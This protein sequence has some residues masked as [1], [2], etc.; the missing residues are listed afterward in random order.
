MKTVGRWVLMVAVVSFIPK[1]FAQGCP[2]TTFCVTSVTISPGEIGG[3][4]VQTAI[5]QVTVSLP[6]G[7]NAYDI[8]IGPGGGAVFNACLPPAVLAGSYACYVTGPTSSILLSGTNSTPSILTAQVRVRADPYADPGVTSSFLIDPVGQAANPPNQPDTT[9]PDCARGGAPINFTTGNTWIEQTDYNI[10]GLTGGLHLT[11]TWNSLWPLMLPVQQVGLFGDS[12]TSNFE[13]RIQALS[14]G[15]VQYWKAGGSRLFYQYNNGA[16][17]Y[18]LTAPLDDQ[19]TISVNSG[20]GVT[21]ILQK[22]G[23]KK[24]FN[25]AGYLTSIIDRNGNTTTITLD[26]A[27]QNRILSVTDPAG[28]VLTFNYT[29][30]QFPRLCTSISDSVGTAATYVYDSS[31]RLSSVTYPDSS[32]YVFQYNSSIS[33]TLISQVNDSVGKIVEAHTYDSQRRGLT[34]KQANGVNL[35]TVNQYGVGYTNIFDSRGNFFVY[36]YTTISQRNHAWLSSGHGCSTCGSTLSE[37]VF[38]TRTGYLTYQSDPGETEP[39]IY[40]YD[41]AGNVANVSKLTGSSLVRGGWG[42]WNYTYNSFGEV[43][44]ATDPLGLAGDPNHTTVNVYDSSGNLLTTTTP[45]PDGGITAG[46][47]TTFTYYSNGTLKTV[48]DPL[49]NTTTLTYYPNGVLGAGQIATIT[50]AQSN[51]TTYTYDARGNR[52]SIQ[53]PENGPAYPTVFTYDSMNRLKTITYPAATA[54]ITFDY[55]WRGRRDWV[56]DQNGLKTYYGYDDAD[57]LTSVTDAQSPTPGVTT[58]AYDTENNLTDI[59]DAKQNHTHMDYTANNVWLSKITFPSGYTESYIYREYWQSPTDKTDRNGQTT[60]YIYDYQDRLAYTT[61]PDGTWRQ[62][63]YDV[64]GRLSSVVDSSGTYGFLYDNMNRLTEADTTYAFVS[65]GKKSVKYG[66]DAG[67]NRKTMTDPQ[68][69][70]TTYGYDTLNRLGTLAFNGQ[71]PGFTFGY[72]AL[73]RRT[74]LTRPNGINTS[75]SYDPASSL[76]AYCTNWAAP[77]WMGRA[78]P[79]MRRRTARRAP[80]SAWARR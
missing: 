10:P 12:W 16:G 8:Y 22:D 6:P 26:P 72:D 47:T 41:S 44:T 58:Y 56:Q 80:T 62:Q 42:T 48:Q 18:A 32:Q 30:A 25:S 23:T 39:T 63:T 61:F 21:T 46:S 15:A 45:S 50:D 1:A 77:R 60:H 35:V 14:G 38:Y 5:A 75:Y 55:D 9:C 11:R 27:N 64:A 31:G 52:L 2:N 67:S 71:N 20:T 40:T 49:G 34:S 68:S 53:D 33:P 28:R 73:S 43:L 24:L 70:V 17:T 59:Y 29:N 65:L 19:T 7:L 36:D 13:E 69:L 78:T 57:R 66:Y 76:T 79:T 3:D 4:G 74:L 54:S 37:K 51:V